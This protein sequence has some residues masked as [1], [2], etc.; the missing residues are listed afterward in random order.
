[1]RITKKRD[2]I[3]DDFGITQNTYRELYYF[4]RQYQEKKQKLNSMIG[5]SAVSYGGMPHGSDISDPTV[6]QAIIR[7]S[8]LCDV[9][10]IES[11]LLEA[12]DCRA[13]YTALL[14][15]VTQG[16]R[17]DNLTVFC[18]RNQFFRMRRKFFFILA[19]KRGRV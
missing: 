6:R 13:H 10:Q 5:L 3:L 16:I 2:L 14:K 15:N 12:T 17:F 18:G 19:R 9:E 11:A 8:C 4:C 1:M 7:E